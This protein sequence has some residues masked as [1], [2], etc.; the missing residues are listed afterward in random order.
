MYVLLDVWENMY[1]HVEKVTKTV[2]FNAL[3][4]LKISPHSVVFENT[5]TPLFHDIYCMNSMYICPYVCN[6]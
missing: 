4:V 6:V 5:S 3:K 1:I 2:F